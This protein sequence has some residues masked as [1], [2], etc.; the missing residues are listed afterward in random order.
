MDWNIFE[1]AFVNAWRGVLPNR[2]WFMTFV[3]LSLCGILLVFC[4]ALA[5][6]ANAWIRLSLLFLPFF[7]SSSFLLIVGV[8]LIRIYVHEKKGLAL[9]TAR[10]FGGSVGTAIGTSYFSFPSILAYMLLWI[11]LG[12]FFLLKEIPYMGPFFN[13]IFAFGPFILILGSLILCLLNVGLL[14]FVAPAAAH[15][16]I[17]SM[18]FV[19]RIWKS[20]CHRPFLSFFLFLIGLIPVLFIGG[21][22]TMAALLTNLNFSLAAPSIALALEWFFVMLPFC[23]LLSPAV[24]FFFHFAEESYQILQD[25]F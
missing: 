2:K 23:A 8:L 3:A 10:L 4:R 6:E 7:L 13:V 17:K 1:K 5:L 12:F 22:L 14:F 15:Q 16:S 19:V 20:I 24:I 25:N 21:M 11:A 18:D 9:S